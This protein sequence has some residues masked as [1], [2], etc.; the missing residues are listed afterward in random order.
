MGAGFRGPKFPGYPNAKKEKCEAAEDILPPTYDNCVGFGNCGCVT[1]YKDKREAEKRTFFPYAMRPNDGV[2][3][4]RRTIGKEKPK[5]CKERILSTVQRRN[6]LPKIRRK[7]PI[8]SSKAGAI[9]P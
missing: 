5:S 4:K 7:K 1:V 8:A 9:V 3:S 2:A 6:A